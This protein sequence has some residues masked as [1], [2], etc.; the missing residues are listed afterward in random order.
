M[1]CDRQLPAPRPDK[2]KKKVDNQLHVSFDITNST[3]KMGKKSKSQ[4]T[5]D[6]KPKATTLPFGGGSA[7][8]PT[9]SSLFAQSV[10]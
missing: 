8:D 3:L 7:L 10:C 5:A 2:Q 4:S 1:S 9:L 6:D